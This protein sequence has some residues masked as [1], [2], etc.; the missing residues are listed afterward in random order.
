ME[1]VKAASTADF[2][3]MVP[4]IAGGSVAQSIVFVPF[5]GKRSLGGACRIGL[6]TRDRRADIRTVV[7]R[8]V[9]V[10]SRLPGVDRVDVVI[11]TDRTFEGERGIPHLELGRAAVNGLQ[12][13]GFHIGLAACVAADGWGDYLERSHQDVGH[14][15]GDIEASEAGVRARALAGDDE[16]A[17]WDREVPD[18]DP[19][20][21]QK[22]ARILGLEPADSDEELVPFS[23]E[24]PTVDLFEMVLTG[25]PEPVFVAM[26]LVLFD[27][28]AARDAALL[29]YAFGRDIGEAAVANADR[30]ATVQRATGKT[31][32]ALVEE[33]MAA[34]ESVDGVEFG[35]MLLGR[36]D[37]IPDRERLGAAIRML[38]ALVA[39]APDDLR[40]A[41]LTM[42]GW[43]LWAIGSAS[44]AGAM[45]DRAIAESPEYRMAGLLR[46][47]V[48]A[49]ALPDW[50][51]SLRRDLA[52]GG[53]EC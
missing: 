15:L 25:C 47:W 53:G 38:R 26:G 19:A 32:D 52:L 20:E 50:L 39:H 14:P 28:P 46:T 21:R 37:R 42:L 16:A 2:L 44:A 24:L 5:H 22:V 4:S 17:S 31:M 23:H 34:G 40:A 27:G 12:R 9:G 35:D 7:H 8:A 18:A 6:P 45:L 3:A 41:P 30:W 43:C 10:M 11:Y 1:I 51:F 48:D 49:G 13:A 33:E 36:T 29:H